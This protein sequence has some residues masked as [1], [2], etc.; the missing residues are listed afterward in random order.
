MLH[1]SWACRSALPCLCTVAAIICALYI[2]MYPPRYRKASVL[3][4]AFPV[5]C[6]FTHML[7]LT[8]NE[9]IND[10]FGR[11][12]LIWMAHMSYEITI[13]E[14]EPQIAPINDGWK[15]RLKHAYSVL[16]DRNHQPS[17]E[18]EGGY[19]TTA[20]KHT[21]STFG[22]LQHHVG[23]AI[24]LALLTYVWNTWIEP[25]NTYLASDFTP[26]KA[27]FFRRLPASLDSR[28]L[29]NRLLHT[30]D[31]CIIDMFRYETI[32]SV[33]A[34]LFVSLRLDSAAEWSLSLFGSLAEA[35]SMRRYWGKHWHN[36]IYHSFSAHV[37]IVTRHWIGLE[38]GRVYTRLIENTL[39]F[40]ASGIMHS[41]VRRAQHKGDGDTWCVTI[42]YSAQMIPIVVEGILQH[43]WAKSKI[44]LNL[45]VDGKTIG[46]LEM[47]VGYAWV[48]SWFLW[49]VPKYH[50]TKYAWEKAILRSRY[51][52][53]FQ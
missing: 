35:H 28:E 16:F 9:T 10:T 31:W 14:Y 26:D 33:F 17:S 47:L 49:C 8:T 7:D 30:F 43:V 39:V 3:L 24:V 15:P 51:P 12:L 53:A 37:K 4:L 38:K 11:F 5:M 45:R 42:L 6:A 34:I 50:F 41:M 19:N 21:Y 29:R 32:H 23:K 22:F 18:K 48:A 25:P 52:E 2:L 46:M 27:I 36:Y 44:H 20:P 13:I 1:Q 40:V